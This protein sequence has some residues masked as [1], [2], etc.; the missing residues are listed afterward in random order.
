M[1]PPRH[2]LIIVALLVFTI[3]SGTVGFRV[4]EG[5]GFMDALYMTI[6]TIASVGY[7][8]IHPRGMPAGSS[9]WWLIFSARAQ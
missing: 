4:I 1:S 7:Q 5:W 9:T 3:T 2:F 8:E 6:I